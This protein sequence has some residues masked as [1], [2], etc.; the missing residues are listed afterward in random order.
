MMP[1]L[2]PLKCHSASHVANRNA[3]L[4]SARGR[5]ASDRWRWRATSAKATVSADELDTPPPTGTSDATSAS[6]PRAQRPDPSAPK[7]SQSKGAAT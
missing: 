4:P 3:L 1:P 6:Q 5:S 7:R 2:S